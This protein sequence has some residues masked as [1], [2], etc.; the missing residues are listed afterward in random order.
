MLLIDIFI[1]IDCDDPIM[2]NLTL[3][4]T[5][6]DSGEN[7]TEYLTPPWKFK[8]PYG[9]AF[10]TSRNSTNTMRCLATG[11]WEYIGQCIRINSFYAT[12]LT[13]E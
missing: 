12:L 13:H 4:I 6:L 11:E 2:L 8:C 7:K 1:A 10:N 9:Y 3:G 5:L